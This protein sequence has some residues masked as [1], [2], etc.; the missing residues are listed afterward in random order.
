MT[1]ERWLEEDKVVAVM[2]RFSEA[3]LAVGTG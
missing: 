3:V 1:V 2:Q